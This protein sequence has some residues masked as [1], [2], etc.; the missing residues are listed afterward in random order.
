MYFFYTRLNGFSST[1]SQGSNQSEYLDQNNIKGKVINSHHKKINMNELNVVNYE[2][3]EP[4]GR[5]PKSVLRK[6]KT[7]SSTIKIK[8]GSSSSNSSSSAVNGHASPIRNSNSN[9][10]NNSINNNNG[11][12][13]GG[14]LSNVNNR[15]NSN[16]YMSSNNSKRI[17]ST[18]SSS[19]TTSRPPHTQTRGQIDVGTDRMQQ[20]SLSTR[21]D[22]QVASS[23]SSLGLTMRIGDG[24]G[25]NGADDVDVDTRTQS[26]SDS[27]IPV[28]NKYTHQITAVNKPINTNTR[29]RTTRRQSSPQLTP[30]SPISLPSRERDRS[31]N[32][33]NG[34]ASRG[35]AQSADARGVTYSNGIAAINSNTSN[36]NDN[37]NNNNN[38]NNINDNNSIFKSSTYREK[39][40][41]TNIVR[42][43][44]ESEMKMRQIKDGDKGR[45]ST[46]PGL[47]DYNL[48]SNL[49]N[50]TQ[51]RTTGR[52][53]I[54]KCNQLSN[55]SNQHQQ[56][57]VAPGPGTGTGTGG[58]TGGRGGTSYS[59]MK[60]VRMR[61]PSFSSSHSL[62][63]SQSPS[64]PYSRI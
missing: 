23:L 37:S 45:D 46:I 6:A 30:S 28:Y 40:F 58:G 52:P 33:E 36:F 47:V 31:L 13:N 55:T 2:E 9:G 3:P 14:R 57:P 59:A 50:T 19:R 44:G 49:N 27:M 42:Y 26:L 43:V 4:I 54:P 8:K 5:I 1:G 18:P 35:R 7:P 61:P 39:D 32:R 11:N 16:Q 22:E 60:A 20:Y 25:T 12:D 51:S 48:H 21:F 15:A 24:T 38:N 64:S 63:L 10:N 17:L 34:E 62:V 53:P 56:R 29:T 41:N